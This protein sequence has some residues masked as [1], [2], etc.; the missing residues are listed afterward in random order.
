MVCLCMWGGGANAK[1]IHVPGRLCQ[2]PGVTRRRAGGTLEKRN[3][4]PIQ[5]FPHFFPRCWQGG[6]CCRRGLGWKMLN[7]RLHSTIYKLLQ[8]LDQVAAPSGAILENS[9]FLLE[10]E[11]SGFPGGSDTVPR[12]IWRWASSRQAPL[13]GHSSRI[14]L[15]SGRKHQGRPSCKN[16]KN[17]IQ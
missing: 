12:P 3:P 4:T 13:E 16:T 1:V 9:C 7:T 6:F 11:H 15:D 14:K 2:R 17:G 5:I 8:K 10:T